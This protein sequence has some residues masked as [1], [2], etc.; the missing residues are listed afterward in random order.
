MG[1]LAT[2]S[3]TLGVPHPPGYPTM[4]LLTWG[5]EKIFY[6]VVGGVSEGTTW[7]VGLVQNYFHCLLSAAANVALFATSVR[8]T[9]C[10]ESALLGSIAYALAPLVWTY[11]NHV[12][13]F[14]LNNLL[15]NSLL[16][17]CVLYYNAYTVDMRRVE[18]GVSK[19]Q[20]KTRRFYLSLGAFVCGL[21][22][23]NQHTSLL[24]VGPFLLWI[25]CLDFRYLILEGRIAI[26]ALY[27]AVGMLPYVYL[28]LAKIYNPNPN[29]WG[30]T[31][32]WDGFWTHFLR[33]EYGTFSLASQEA[34]YRSAD[35]LRAWEYYAKDL[36]VQIGVF[37]PLSVLAI[38]H[39]L[40]QAVRGVPI[41]PLRNSRLTPE[42]VFLATLLIYL[43]VFNYLCN[44]PIDQPLFFGVQQRF[45][46]QPLSICCL[47]LGRGFAMIKETAI[48]LLTKAFGEKKTTTTVTTFINTAFTLGAAI[49]AMQLY[50]QSIATLD[51]SNNY[52]VRDFGRAILEPLPKNAIVLTKGDIMINSAR[53]VQTLEKVRED[54]TLL[55]QEMLTYSWYVTSFE[56]SQVSVGSSQQVR[57]PGGCYF[58]FRKGCFDIAEFIAANRK[59]RVFLAHGWKDGDNSWKGKYSAMPYGVIHEA[60]PQRRRNDLSMS[61]LKRYKSSQKG[62]I[63]MPAKMP[64]NNSSSLEWS[65]GTLAWR[66]QLP[67]EGK[68]QDHV[69]EKVV[70][71]DY[72]M[73]HQN[74]A[75]TL[76]DWFSRGF[77]E[78]G[79]VYG[80]K[81]TAAYAA[82]VEAGERLSF[83][84]DSGVTLRG[85]V[86]RNY[87]VV[88]QNLIRYHPEDV[89]LVRRIVSVL[90]EYVTL[91]ES[92]PKSQQHETAS[93]NEALNHYK[94]QLKGRR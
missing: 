84:V 63:P 9:Q 12:E 85:L 76:L 6:G 33:K 34:N 5:A 30:E 47:I 66:M 1:E 82:L 3:H 49:L 81:G 89:R 53:Y 94:A 11:A 21:N 62:S 60:V 75:L 25:V 88:L 20:C 17:S 65:V 79:E 54:V 72:W 68:Y 52:I 64:Q 67:E 15:V 23:T 32:S 51:Q 31:E 2:V 29:S 45:W 73:A 42:P 70:E 56:K 22:I 55:D 87:G 28:P 24:F 80:D 50:S 57:F 61:Q 43:N 90:Q 8:I 10:G 74:V 46:I 36:V 83:M 41:T 78:G 39:T 92:G 35:F 13:V 7:S 91:Q 93:I 69:W 38:P 18:K 4:T 26:L 19:A 44:L 86:L 71:G 59:R 40:L 37:L 27:F 48:T 14:A 58:P 77:K 16:L